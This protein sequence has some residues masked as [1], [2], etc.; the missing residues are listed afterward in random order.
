VEAMGLDV[1]AG[2]FLVGRYGQ[3]SWIAA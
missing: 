2:E 3:E 1:E